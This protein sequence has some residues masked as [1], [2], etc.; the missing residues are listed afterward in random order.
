MQTNMIDNNGNIVT[1]NMP[2]DYLTGMDMVEMKRPKPAVYYTFNR[3]NG[4]WDFDLN[5]SKNYYLEFLNKV[6]DTFIYLYI[7]QSPFKTSIYAK[8]IQEASMILQGTD[9]PNELPILFNEASLKQISLV[10]LANKVLLNA[11]NL[12]NLKNN[13]ELLK[14]EYKLVIDRSVDDKEMM[15]AINDL[16]TKLNR[17]K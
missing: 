8:K 9:N 11:S 4:D 10:D 2:L 15:I 7:D 3:F 6:L 14:V 1:S 16:Q 17:L 13:V 5:L 12:D